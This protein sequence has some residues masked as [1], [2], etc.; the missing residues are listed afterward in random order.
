MQILLHALGE[1][2]SLQL[3]PPSPGISPSLCA[4]KSCSGA[5]DLLKFFFYLQSSQ[6]AHSFLSG[7]ASISAFVFSASLYIHSL[8]A[9]FAFAF[10]LIMMPLLCSRGFDAQEELSLAF[11]S[12]T[13]T[14]R[15][16]LRPPLHAEGCN[17]KA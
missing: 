4:K 3:A 15:Q 5:L 7:L 6:D 2:V 17:P 12:P 8:K 16:Q 10:M 14:F 11:G 9:I 13:L 1:A